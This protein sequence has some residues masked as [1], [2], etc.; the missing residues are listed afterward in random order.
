MTLDYPCPR[1]NAPPAMQGTCVNSDREIETACRRCK[2]TWLCNPGWP[3]D[4]RRQ[5]DRNNRASDPA[6]PHGLRHIDR[7]HHD[8]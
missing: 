6:A 2:W 5:L 8:R 1:C 4:D 3:S 7:R